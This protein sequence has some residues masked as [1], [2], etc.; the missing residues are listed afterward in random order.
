MHH[1]L[2][3]NVPYTLYYSYLASNPGDSKAAVELRDMKFLQ[4][5]KGKTLRKAAITTSSPL[6]KEEG[7]GDSN[8]GKRSGPRTRRNSMRRAST[9]D[10]VEQRAVTTPGLAHSLYE[11]LGLPQVR[12]PSPA[13]LEFLP[14]PDL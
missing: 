7:G 12:H 1:H 5:Q 9:T 6:A 11:V 4:G 14:A 3:T 2:L 13:G 10:G 8:I